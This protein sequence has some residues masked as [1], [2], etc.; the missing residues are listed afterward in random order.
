MISVLI[1]VHNEEENV[2]ILIHKII[3]VFAYNNIKDFEIIIIDDN[4]TDD[5]GAVADDISGKNPAVRVIH[6]VGEPGVGRALKAGFKESKGNV[7]ITL[8]GDLSH[9]P[10]EIPRILSQIYSGADLVIGSRYIQGGSYETSFVRMVLTRTYN[11]TLKVLS[12]SEIS[13]FTTGYR[14]MKRDILNSIQLLSNGFAI[15]PELHIKSLRG[16]FDVKE[17][18][19]GYYKRKGG[20]SKLR[21][22]KEGFGYIKVIQYAIKSRRKL[23]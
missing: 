3:K 18:P 8:D 14:G 2:E 19:I 17:T 12:Q 1:P 4:S 11:L 23:I 5:T 7:I 13:D 22:R 15:H 9:N 6:R 21:Y 10:E 16:G 20:K